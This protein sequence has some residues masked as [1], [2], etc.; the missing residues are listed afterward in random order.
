M[1]YRV[2]PKVG[3]KTLL[4]SGYGIGCAIRYGVLRPSGDA[5]D[6]VEDAA[7]FNELARRGWDAEIDA[8][9]SQTKDSD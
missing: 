6:G 1:F 4:A 2:L 9:R 7:G 3:F 8:G 5:L